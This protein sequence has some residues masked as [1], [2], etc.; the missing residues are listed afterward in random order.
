MFE[1]NTTTNSFE[2]LVDGVV[3]LDKRG[4]PLSSPNLSYLKQRVRNEGIA[5]SDALPGA[6]PSV[7]G[8]TQ[9]IVAAP[10]S[11]F[12]VE[13]RFNFIER[14]TKGVATGAYLSL[15]LVGGPGLG[16]THVVLQTLKDLGLKEILPMNIEPATKG[17][18][19]D[20]EIQEMLMNGEPLVDEGDFIVIKG[21]STP[22]ALYR[23]LYDNNGKII[24]IDDA[25][26]AFGDKNAAN[27]LKGALDSS[28]PRYISWMTEKKSNDDD[29]PSRFEFT[30]RI[31]FISNLEMSQFPAAILSR[32]VHVDLTLT[33]EEKIERI[34]LILSKYEDADGHAAQVLGLIKDH[35]PKF[36]EL[37]VRTAMMLM[38]IRKAEPDDRLFTRMA[39]YHATA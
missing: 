19:A 27:I 17:G 31:I 34:E 2:Y 28:V 15:V 11:E 33:T 10:K 25:D 32:S 24:V 35:A 16:K 22:K 1:F 29:L 12:T 13:E 36:K 21:F 8:L 38:Q 3:M 7:S 5:V 20:E 30:G 26:G 37:S 6:A 14:F 39:L 18:E 23:A 9:A 4:K